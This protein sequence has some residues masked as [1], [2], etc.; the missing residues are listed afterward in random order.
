[1]VISVKR[2]VFVGLGLLAVLVRC[3]GGSSTESNNSPVA[4]Q[5]T[6][7]RYEQTIFNGPYGVTVDLDNPEETELLYE[8][9]QDH[10]YFNKEVLAL[11]IE[12]SINA[13]SDNEFGWV[14]D[15]FGVVLLEEYNVLSWLVGC[16]ETFPRMFDE[17]YTVG[18]ADTIDNCSLVSNYSS[19]STDRLCNNSLDVLERKITAT[20]DRIRTLDEFFE[21]IN[22]QLN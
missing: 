12:Q 6:D 21:E 5:S 10:M 14:W 17:F 8:C 22:E 13:Y 18:L 9:I 4:D 3:G 19:S 20:G 15:D 16:E 1:M 11:A 2:F 7:S